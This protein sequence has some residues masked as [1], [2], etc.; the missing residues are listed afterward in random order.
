MI[1]NA[2]RLSV[3]LVTSAGWPDLAPDD[4]LILPALARAGVACQI[5]VWTDQS[6]DWQ[7]FDSIVIRSCWDYHDDL[8][9]WLAFIEALGGT[10]N[11][12]SGSTGHGARRS[13]GARL[14]NAPPALRWSARKTYLADLAARGIPVVPISWIEASDLLSWDLLKGALEA[15]PWG[16]FVLK[17]AVSAGALG[18]FHLRRATLSS[19]ES[20][21][22]PFLP[23]LARRGPALVQPFLPA[24][25]LEGEWS[26]LFFNGRLSHAVVKRPA[27]GDFRVQEK[28]GG[29]TSAAV[30][31]SDLVRVAEQTMRAACDASGVS[32]APRG[33]A[34]ESFLYA[35]VDLVMSG[36]GPLLMELELIEPALFL[37]TDHAAADRF[38]EALL[39]RTRSRRDHSRDLTS[40]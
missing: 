9:R 39:A 27:A 28:H 15:T 18:T 5:V 31:P 30:P 7:R 29:T 17:P 11:L 13:V 36:G 2:E 6:I 20:A 35:R 38:A 10:D 26:L 19:S 1:G 37:G 16:D 33:A 40:S 21:L 32:T 25:T 14:W 22:K 4:R 34:A 23:E 12:I 3:A 24:I 8:P